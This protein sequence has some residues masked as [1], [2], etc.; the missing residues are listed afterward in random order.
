MALA[1]PRPRLEGESWHE[2]FKITTSESLY[3]SRGLP[4]N[5]ALV[6]VNDEV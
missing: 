3:G 1:G 6:C 5:L 4:Q 2:A